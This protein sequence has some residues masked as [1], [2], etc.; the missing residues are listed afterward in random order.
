MNL[1]QPIWILL[2]KWN[3]G[4]PYKM[5]VVVLSFFCSFVM[6]SDAGSK[7]NGKKGMFKQTLKVS[8]VEVGSGLLALFR[9]MLLLILSSKGRTINDLGGLDREVAMSFS[10]AHQ[11]MTF[12]WATC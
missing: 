4:N 3:I 11:L 7:S 9:E 8:I 6:I 1:I 10:L 5:T 12:F 2:N